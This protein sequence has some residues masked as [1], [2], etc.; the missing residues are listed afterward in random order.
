[1]AMTEPNLH[2][3]YEQGRRDAAMDIE[4][5][6]KRLIVDRGMQILDPVNLVLMA[7]SGIALGGVGPEPTPAERLRDAVIDRIEKE[8]RIREHEA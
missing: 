8:G 2:A 1:M 6:R 4:A 7:A 3:A 5:E